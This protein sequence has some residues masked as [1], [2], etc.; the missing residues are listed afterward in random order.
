MATQIRLATTHDAA[1]ILA[2]YAP[3]VS[4]TSISFE[5]HPPT[6]DEMQQRIATTLTRLPWL[7]CLQN[8]QVIGYAYANPHRTR[9]SYQ[10]SVEVSVYVAH[11]AQRASVGRALYTG[12]FNVL[13]LQG[14]YNAYAV[15]TLPNPSSVHAH[16]VLGFRHI[17]VHREAGYK[18]GQWHDVGWWQLSL[19]PH[20]PHPQPPVSI[21]EVADNEE[22]AAVL[23][24]ACSHLRI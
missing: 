22:F 6:V 4:T 5:L 19:Q 15:I 9:M 3:I 16:E 12:L 13:R 23:K 8:D 11:N 18:L 20:P 7:V 10:W 1:S 21:Q 2:I 14:F 17:G 24:G